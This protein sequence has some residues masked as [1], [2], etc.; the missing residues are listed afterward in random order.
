[1]PNS[2]RVETDTT[3][4]LVA[5]QSEA[6]RLRREHTELKAR[7][8]ELNS[9]LYLSP[10]EELERKTIQKL[11]LQKKDRIAALM[12]NYSGSS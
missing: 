7:L 4:E 11:K 5:H 9:R 1:M 6:E 3:T 10:A 8:N 2:T 12:V